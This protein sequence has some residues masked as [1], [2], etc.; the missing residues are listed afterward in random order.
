MLFLLQGFSFDKLLNE[1]FVYLFCNTPH[2][3]VSSISHLIYEDVFA[4]KGIL[5][6]TFTHNNS[7][8]YFGVEEVDMKMFASII[9]NQRCVKTQYS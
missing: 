3:F 6:C 7:T 2:S 9:V 5:L 4:L 8:E 1:A